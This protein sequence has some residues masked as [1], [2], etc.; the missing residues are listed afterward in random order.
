[1]RVAAERGFVVATAVANELVLRGEPFRK[2]HHRVGA[3]VRRAVDAG[4]SR[5]EPADLPAGA[6]DL[7]PALDAV[8]TR[9]RQGGPGDLGALVTSL[10]QEARD[11]AAWWAEQRERER[12]ADR[13]LAAEVARLGTGPIATGTVR[14]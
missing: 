11:H 5:L 12:E 6:G 10:R 3:A 14:P 7:D 8:V 9:Q 1:M 13:R 2:A 4:R